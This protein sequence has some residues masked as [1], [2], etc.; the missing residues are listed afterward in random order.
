MKEKKRRK[1]LATAYIKQIR[2]NKSYMEYTEHVQKIIFT[3]VSW[4]KKSSFSSKSHNS[5][6]IKAT[7]QT[8]LAIL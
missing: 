1:T 7:D 6:K 8:L 4:E 3:E 2:Q 5:Q